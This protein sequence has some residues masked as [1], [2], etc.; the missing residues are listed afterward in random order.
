MERTL[1]D[2]DIAAIAAAVKVD[3]HCQFSGEEVQFVRDFL[4]MWKETR[5]TI[6]KTL[7][8]LIGMGALGLAALM[9]NHKG[10]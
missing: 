1:T 5:S 9:Y 8:G 2:A 3:H 6:L 7:L 10:G 4:T